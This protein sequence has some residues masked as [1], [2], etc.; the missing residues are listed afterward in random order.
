MQMHV[1]SQPDMVA[2][3]TELVA[4]SEEDRFLLFSL[5][6]P[7]RVGSRNRKW[8]V[9][10]RD[11]ELCHERQPY[12][13]PRWDTDRLP[14]RPERQVGS[15]GHERRWQQPASIGKC[16]RD[17][18]FHALVRPRPNFSLPMR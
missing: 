5:R 1:S 4:G 12:H 13:F 8:C 14:V 9:A 6:D 7:E 15:L 18:S 2:I 17:W 11:I 3:S 10:A 16:R